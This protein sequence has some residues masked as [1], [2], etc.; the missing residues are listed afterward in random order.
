MSNDRELRD[1]RTREYVSSR[2][3]HEPP[4]DLVHSIMREVDRTPQRRAALGWPLVA[5]GLAVAA[6]LLAVAVL[7]TPPS[8]PVGGGPTPSLSPTASPTVG[9]SASAL[10]EP[11]ATPGP[12]ASTGTSGPTI[13]PMPSPS[14]IGP[15]GPVH[16]LAPA[17]AFAVPD[18]CENSVGGYRI[19]MPDDWWYNTAFKAFDAC[20]W[21]ARTT[22]EV[23]DGA[24]IPEEIAIVLKVSDGEYGFFDEV[25]SMEEFTV[26][27]VPALRY[28]FE[29]EGTFAGRSVFWIVGIG[30][31]LPSEANTAPWL[32]ARTSWQLSGDIDENINVLDRMIATLELIEP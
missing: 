22:F 28:E 18:D 24:T 11:T 3:K 21:F 4:P 23:T 12:T 15:F 10:V 19:S 30:G 2:M 26:G 27:G 29:G 5:A 7:T 16:G 6:G 8:G 31:E 20:Q 32:M 17:E 9:P 1:R 13:A 25:I 14:A